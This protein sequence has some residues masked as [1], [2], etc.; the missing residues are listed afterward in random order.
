[1][2]FNSVEFLLYLPV[3]LAG[4]FL[5]PFQVRWAW[6]LGASW[7]FYMCW[8]FRFIILIFAV[9]LI[10][11][12]AAIE[13]QKNSKYKK[14]WL[15][16]ALIL[17]LGEL[18]VFKYANFFTE[19][20]MDL[21]S[22]AGIRLIWE[23]WNILLPVGISFY[24]FQALS[25]VID[26]YRGTVEAEHHFGYYALFVA[27]FPQLVAGPIERSRDLLS[28]LKTEHKFNL[29]NLKAGVWI[30]LGGFFRKCVVADTL[31]IYVDR[32]FADLENA[33][34]LAV[35]CAGL[36]FCI[37]MYCDFAGYSEIA[38]GAARVMGIHLTQN[39]DRPYLSLSYTEFFRRWHITLGRWFSDYVYIPLGGNRRG[40]GRKL[41][42]TV[43]V[44]FLCGLWHG[45]SWNYVLWGL[46]AAFFL[47][48]EAILHK[49]AEKWLKKYQINS[50][51][52]CF[53]LIRRCVML[54]IFVP[55]ALLFRASG[56]SEAGIVIRHLFSGWELRPDYIKENLTFMGISAEDA[57]LIGLCLLGMCMIY[58]FEE[59]YSKVD[60]EANEDLGGIQKSIG[61]FLLMAVIWSGL[62][63]SSGGDTSAFA[64]FQF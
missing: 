7:F 61:V 50:K 5:L 23:K 37:Q 45:A 42:N 14:W 18:A 63:L 11:Y 32:I 21:L 29:E 41:V 51:T 64:Y 57:V 34:G 59:Y 22:L 54:F 39:F 44:F 15:S 24:T 13:I 12:V 25:Y 58:Y 28:Q 60:A 33:E 49:P 48:L 38:M 3:V 46:Y 43:I 52:V 19:S 35:F 26:V 16:A 10:T 27:Y 53:C 20:L 62:S 40:M 31:G 36:L 8:D 17:C 55:A 4:Y 1:M 2:N 56:L 9:T 47:C 6:L 30:M